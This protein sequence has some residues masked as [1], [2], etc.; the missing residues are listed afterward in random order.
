MNNRRCVSGKCKL[1]TERIT[2]V[3]LNVPVANILHNPQNQWNRLCYGNIRFA[4]NG[5]ILSSV[6]WNE[7]NSKNYVIAHCS[8]VSSVSVSKNGY[9]INSPCDELVN[10]NGNAWSTPVLLATFKSFISK[11]IYFEHLQ[12]PSL[13]KGMILDAIARPVIHMGKDGS[14]IKIY[15]IDILTATNRKHIDLA[16]R[17]ESGELATMSMG[18]STDVQCS[19]CGKIFKDGEGSCKHID[20]DLLT[21]FIDENGEK[22]IIAELCGYC[23]KNKYGKWV[24]VPK[25][26]EFIEASW[27]EKPAFRGAVINHLIQDKTYKVANNN[28]SQL[29]ID[30][31][32]K[33]RVADKDSMSAIKVAKNYLLEQKIINNMINEKNNLS[34]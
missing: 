5:H 28:I 16:D 15:Y 21:Y 31:M 26:V 13:S 23:K 17:I 8:I 19:K 27:V 24:G 14:K 3:H 20:D 18:C 4:S 32:F 25:S 9:Y 30:D 10:S 22:R 11:P 33:I 6:D 7:F 12:V 2:N 29:T 1:R 34:P